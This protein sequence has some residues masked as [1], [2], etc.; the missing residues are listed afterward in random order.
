MKKYIVY[1]PVYILLAFLFV[2][3]CADDK[4]NYLYDEKEIITIEMP[5]QITAL[6]FAETVNIEPVITSNLRGNIEND[7]QGF[8]FVSEVK[9]S[10]G[11][12][13][14]LGELNNKDVV[15]APTLP[16]NS[17]YARYSV[18]DKET[19]VRHSKLFYL[20]YLTVTTEGW[21]LLCNEGANNRVRL[22]MLSQLS[23]ERIV[24]AYDVLVTDNTVPELTNASSLAFYANRRSIG[25]KIFLLTETAGYILPTQ[26]NS[27]QGQLATLNE[28]FELKK[29]LF[30]S[31]TS[32]PI[33]KLYSIAR[34]DYTN[35]D[36]IIGVSKG[37][38]AYAWNVQS[39]GGAFELPINTSVRGGTPQ[40]KVE[41]YIGTTLYRYTTGMQSY[42]V[43]LLYD[44]DNKRF[45]G[46][47]S[48]EDTD[49]STGR[50]Q[51]TYPLTG[52]SSDNNLFSFTTGLNLVTMLNTLTTTHS[53]LQDGSERVIYSINVMDNE[54]RQEGYYN[55]I[56]APNFHV[57]SHYAAS[58]QYPVIYYAYQN[59][60]Y[61]YNYITKEYN[62][63]V[64]LDENEE[65]T[66][67]KFN[68]FDEPQGV[69][70]LVQNM[71][72][73]Q[74]SEFRARENE[75]IVASYDNSSADVNGGKLRFYQTTSPGIN[76]T[77]KPGWETEGYARIVDV[78]Y[79]EV[80]P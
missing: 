19:N 32:D 10:D 43:A 41:P 16:A 65:I 77:L 68:R 39:V 71:S 6:A 3:S 34:L 62:E 75:L 27:P 74:A 67:I 7:Q 42:G 76:L 49:G 52:T 15:I 30:L 50:K 17:Y 47:D 72:E 45:I 80:R 61:A 38:D 57:A 11:D 5:T 55:N 60:V 73:N 14:E 56:E 46:W 79:K 13:V 2:V 70:L 23:P 59:K 9:N 54:F 37:G 35:H 31:T 12:W 69:S 51:T 44:K 20:R 40:F 36:M 21:M 53:I 1:P 33:V 26:D 24:P 66:L 63:S 8:E 48:F 28:A 18:I 29:S 58:P 25:N 78:K 64:V 22:D 4:G